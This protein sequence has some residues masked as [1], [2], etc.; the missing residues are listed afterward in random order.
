MVLALYLYDKQIMW[1]S[2]KIYG[3]SNMGAKNENKRE[4]IKVWK[5]AHREK[6]WYH[7]AKRI[8]LFFLH[9]F[10]PHGYIRNY[11]LFPICGFLR[12]N[13]VKPFYN[14][15]IRRLEGLRDIHKDKRCFIIAT[16]PSLRIEDVEKLE[17]EITIGVNTLYRLYENTTFR[18]TYY[19]SL[20]HDGQS[21][22][23]DNIE[24]YNK[25]TKEIVFL[26]S[27]H[28]SS[29]NHSRAEIIHLPLCYQ[30]HW[31]NINNPRFHYD[32]N[33]KY[34]TDVVWGLYDKYT[35]TNVA[36]E[37]AIYMGCKEI[38]LIGV[39]CNYTSSQVHFHKGDNM[40]IDLGLYI[41]KAMT[42]GYKFMERETKKR[43]VH[44]FNATRGGMLEEFE[45][46]NF[47]SIFE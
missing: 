31:F 8:Y 37:L 17:D 46:V 6:V 16:G 40:D 35:I 1:G 21:A 32:K 24:K 2:Y 22:I 11:V 10:Y 45:R 25:F 29:Q 30:N 23:E 19:A 12:K 3:R 42:S 43:G 28:K 15:E 38:Y 27:L 44:I 34:C 41:Q 33:L 47:D 20:D 26:N 13:H 14:R 9:L 39:D 7:M 4:Q 18:P 36:I 5:D